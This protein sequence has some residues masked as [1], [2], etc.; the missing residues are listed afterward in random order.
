MD[1]STLVH[2]IQYGSVF[3]RGLIKTEDLTVF[4]SKNKKKVPNFNLRISDEF[5]EE[6]ACYI[7]RLTFV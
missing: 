5:V 3:I 6:D 7:A 2:W 4:N 1:S